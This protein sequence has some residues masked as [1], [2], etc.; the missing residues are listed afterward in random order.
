MG[1]TPYL[2]NPLAYMLLPSKSQEVYE[3]AFTLFKI[4]AKTQYQNT[5][6]F[7]TDF[8]LAECNAFKKVLMNKTHFFQFCYFHFTQI[9]KRYFDIQNLNI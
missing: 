3:S 5:D 7:I 1:Q 9:L 6:T 8:E 4:E 2:N